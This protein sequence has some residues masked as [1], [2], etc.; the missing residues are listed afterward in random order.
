MSSRILFNSRTSKRAI[1]CFYCALGK[2]ITETHHDLVAVYGEDAPALSVIHRWFQ[3]HRAGRVDLEDNPRPGRPP[4]EGLDDA[5]KALL[6]VNTHAT[7]H[8]IA[9]EL[10]HSVSTITEH[11]HA[12]GLHYFQLRWVP[13][14]LTDEQ[15]ATRVDGARALLAHL[16]QRG[17]RGVS[18]VLTSDE[19]W[20]NHDNPHAAMWCETREDVEMRAQQ[21]VTK[22]KTLVVV[23][24][25]FVGF[26][27]ILAVPHGQTYTSA[28]CISTAF[29]SL[30]AALRP[31]RPK[32]GLSGTC[33]HWD[34]ARPHIANLTQENL[35]SRGVRILPHPPYSPDLAPSDFFLFGYLKGRIMGQKFATSPELVANL[36]QIMSEIGKSVLQKVY[37]EWMG[38]LEWVITHYGEYYHT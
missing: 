10:G 29:P 16:R 14:T 28:F 35:T 21:A 25:N 24:W 4:T 1:I 9:E 13:H 26:N 23:F 30:D 36:S 22:H 6:L 20:F 12:L 15:K 31:N 19:S 34:N 17:A 8:E 33:L 18:T 37:E 32:L 27:H 7:A 11:M 38:R 2:T 3:R 5:L